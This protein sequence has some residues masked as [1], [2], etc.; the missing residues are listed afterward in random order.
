MILCQLDMQKDGQILRSYFSKL[1]YQFMFITTIYIVIISYLNITRRKASSLFQID[2][3]SNPIS[4]QPAVILLSKKFFIAQ[5]RYIEPC[6]IPYCP[7]RLTTETRHAIGNRHR[8]G[9]ALIPL[10]LLVIDFV[11]S[12][13]VHDLDDLLI[14]VQF[15]S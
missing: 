12:S 3:L 2:C 6:P 13:I 10:V 15:C 7:A 4:V 14:F 11:F 9:L 1:S 5:K 8:T